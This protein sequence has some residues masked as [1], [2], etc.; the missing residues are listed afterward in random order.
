MPK[1]SFASLILVVL[2]V[3]SYSAEMTIAPPSFL[4]AD[5]SVKM[6]M[7]DTLQPHATALWQAVR[8][9]VTE[10]GVVE[11]VTPTSDDDWNRLRDSALRLIEGAN[12]LLLPGRPIDLLPLA[13]DYPDWQYPPEEIQAMVAANPRGWLNYI[14]QMQQSTRSTLETI[15]R[16]DV[17]GLMDVGGQINNACQGCHAE[18]WYRPN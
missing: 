7:N 8:Y 1:R 2:A 11:D 13:Q 9:T 10:A 15:E 12:A 4:V 6:L 5:T 3:A 18:F 16:K 17:Q 14:Q